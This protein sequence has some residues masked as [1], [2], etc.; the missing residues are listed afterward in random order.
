MLFRFILV[1]LCIFVV[2]AC[3]YANNTTD[4]ALVAVSKATSD[5][6]AQPVH[7]NYEKYKLANGLTV[8]L[9][10]DTSDPLVHVDMTYHVGS[11]REL[12]G[13][14]GFAHFFEH[15]MFQGSEN[16][17]D[18]QHFKIVTDAGGTLNG[19]TNRDRTNYFQ[20][21]PANQLEK[22]LWLEADRMGFLLPAVTQEKFEIQRETVK[23]ERA[24]RVDNQPYGRR[25]EKIAEALYPE[26]HPYGWLTIGYVEDLDRVNVNDL[27]AFFQRW[28]G[29]NNA[30]LTIGG[31]IDIA[32]TKAWISRYFSEIP[33]GPDIPAQAPGIAQL[34]EN[35]FV[36]LEDNI[37][38]PLL[39]IVLPTV[40]AR[41]EDEAALD[42][43]SNILGSGK[44]S[45]FYESLVKTGKAVQAG[46]SHPCSELACEF[47]LMALISPE[48]GESLA[49][50]YDT[51]Q[52]ML[53]T[54]ESRPFDDDALLRVKAS[55][56]ASTIYGLQS[57]SGKVSTM[58]YNETFFGNPNLIN[59]D[60]ARYNNVTKEDVYRVFRK[61]IKGQKAV[62]LS[63][64]PHGQSALA[65]A[66][67][68]FQ[69]APREFAIQQ[70]TTSIDVARQTSRTS[71]AGFDRS[72]VPEAGPAPSVTVPEYWRDRLDNGMQIIG[73]TSDETP[74]VSFTLDM[75][76]GMLLDPMEKAGLSQMT[77]MMMNETTQGYSNE[78]MSN[79]LAKLGS[80]ISFTSNGRYTQVFVSSLT[81]NLD[82]T[83]ALLKEKLFRPA[84]LESDFD[85]LKKQVI[86]GINSQAKNPSALAERATSLVLWGKQNRISLSQTGTAET[87]QNITL[88]DVKRFY[89]N[90]YVP[91][92]STLVMVGDIS[93]AAL[94]DRL[95][96][97]SDWQG[98]DYTIP[99]YA[100]F[101]EYQSNQIYLVDVPGA[102]QST[103]RM[104]SRSLPYDAT[105]DYFH[106]QLMNFPLGDD[107]NSRIN[108]NLRE[109]KGYT[110]GAYSSF[111]GG[112][113][114]GWFEAGAELKQQYT[115]AGIVELMKEINQ[116]KQQGITEAE[117]AFMQNAFTLSEALEYE[118]P[119]DK[120]AFLRRL[121]AYDL[122]SDYKQTQKS[123]IR[124]IAKPELDKVA[125]R[126]LNTQDLQIIIVGDK[127]ALQPQL[128]AL[129]MP[130]HDISFAGG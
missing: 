27:K 103:V 59:E 125:S 78:A 49:G 42:V 13:K 126:L 67:Q 82:A 65:A 79:E 56:K 110:Y 74:T 64:V 76:G 108:Q 34:S 102:T 92:K 36:T 88:D 19:T 62:V 55:I 15:M 24:E 111:N 97:L 35:R 23:N 16:V 113:S 72:V 21:V 63:V 106:A 101:P 51:I 118:T 94:I 93:Q 8:I 84:F 91:A 11:A 107:F 7:I 48:S 83:L 29:P 38:L 54:F 115:E 37:H 116:Y 25:H 2:S 22:V 39:Q 46:V 99:G 57:V 86:D 3:Q 121:V 58:A 40:H 90:Y 75:E 18:E 6:V 80:S 43:L 81:E 71:S 100:S 50:M 32:Q 10:Q 69:S 119:M 109:D 33:A 9:H 130:V 112:K 96:F 85:R 105:G 70:E 124:G 5:S 26:G 117:L 14:T 104:V 45:L 95:A 73:V 128:E 122:P 61:Y 129:A 1:G 114:L 87:I 123:I 66:P 41:H 127:Q 4:S 44:T 12:P 98:S 89:A 120:A 68:T 17:A 31:D 30:V 77:A 20:T 52:T 47:N 60:I 28:Y 53:D